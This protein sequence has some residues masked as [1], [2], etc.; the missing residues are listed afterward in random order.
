[1]APPRDLRRKLSDNLDNSAGSNRPSRIRRLL[2]FT[3]PSFSKVGRQ[4]FGAL[5]CLSERCPPAKENRRARGPRTTRGPRTS[6]RGRET[7]RQPRLCAGATEVLVG[8]LQLRHLVLDH[9]DPG[10][11]LHVIRPWLEQR[12][13]RGDRLGLAAGFA[14]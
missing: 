6:K 5:L 12:R 4:T 9:L 11:L 14:L 7:P 1:M 8:F 10:R 13:P 3:Q 2:S